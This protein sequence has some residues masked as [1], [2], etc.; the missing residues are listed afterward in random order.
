M[1][2]IAFVSMGCAVK[3]EGLRVATRFSAGQGMP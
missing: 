1:P 2:N 3:D